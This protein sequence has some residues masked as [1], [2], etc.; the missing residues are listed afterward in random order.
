MRGG[1]RGDAG[2]VV[3]EDDT[4]VEEE[5]AGEVLAK[6]RRAGGLPA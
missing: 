5:D 4:A 2:E 6:M 1:A 3:E